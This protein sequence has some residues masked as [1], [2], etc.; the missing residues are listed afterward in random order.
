MAETDFQQEARHISEFE[1]YLE[2]SGMNR[3]ATCPFV[4]KHL[5]TKR[6]G[7]RQGCWSHCKIQRLLSSLLAGPS[8]TAI[9][10]ECTSR[11]SSHWRLAKG[12]Q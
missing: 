6:Y 1:N 3:V 11:I 9:S 8:K 10:Q 2:N 5:T 12:T 7:G 4:Y